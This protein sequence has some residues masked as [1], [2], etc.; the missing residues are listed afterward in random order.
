MCDLVLMLS[1][2]QIAHFSFKSIKQFLIL[3]KEESNKSLGSPPRGKGGQQ[4]H[5]AYYLKGREATRRTPPRHSVCYHD[6]RIPVLP[7]MA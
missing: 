3:C 1:Q 7:S 4:W 5:G 6:L 2:D